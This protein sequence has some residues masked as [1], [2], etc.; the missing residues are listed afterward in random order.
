MSPKPKKFNLVGPCDPEAH[1]LLP[2]FKRLPDIQDLINH[3]HYFVLH[4]PR[5]SGKTTTIKAAVE[6]IN[7]KG[8]Y[9]ALYCSLEDARMVTDRDEAMGV[10]TGLLDKALREASFLGLEATSLAEALRNFDATSFR[11]L[12]SV[13]NWLNFICGQLDKNLLIFFDQADRLAESPFLVFLSLLKNEY[14]TR[15]HIYSHS[16]RSIAFI[17]ERNIINRELEILVEKKL[18]DSGPPFNVVAKVLTLANFTLEEVK[19]L[20]AQH[21]ATT[22]QVF[23]DAA[24]QRAHYWTDGQPWL[25]NALANEVSENI[26]GQDYK[27]PITPGLIDQAVDN[28]FVRMDGHLEYL[29]SRLGESRVQRFISPMLT[30]G[31]TKNPPGDWFNDQDFVHSYWR[32]Y[33]YSLDLGLIKGD[34]LDYEIANPI[35]ARLITEYFG[36]DLIKPFRA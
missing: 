10:I 36:R 2:P 23:G 12:F 7:A 34:D 33:K 14:E 9:R 15:R 18:L 11:G 19:S 22:G 4:A 17:G 21:T 27:A 5:Q 1:Y 30:P 20:Y 6:A 32:D 8:E 29:N 3:G 25:V 31:K 24:T 28:L 35:Y 16:P 26:L 13:N